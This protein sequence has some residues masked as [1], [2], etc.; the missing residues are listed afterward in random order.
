MS[1]RQRVVLAVLALCFVALI[2]VCGFALATDGGTPAPGGV[3]VQGSAALR[4]PEDDAAASE[5]AS[6]EDDEA[7][8]T[9]SGE[10]DS[11]SSNASDQSDDSAG[12]GA[13]DQSS[14]NG[15]DRD[16][17]DSSSSHGG[18]SGASKGES[19]QKTVTVSVSIDSSA[20]DGSVSGSGTFTFKEG[21]TPYDALCALR[22][23]VT[24]SST[25]MGIYVE[26]IGGLFENDSR[27]P[28]VSGWKY[29]V[30]GQV[31]MQSAGSY[32]LSD[33]DH[34]TWYY[35]VTG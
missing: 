34:V 33:G 22:S 35:T 15:G 18:S 25:A 24:S 27:Y 16:T 32:T 14:S 8:A 13:S 3:A 5:D 12:S 23:D 28:G 26:G 21:A 17:S 1:G 30:N 9:P 6:A 4:A 7:A 20:A 10:G 2:A 31:V 11:S 19:Q 29:M